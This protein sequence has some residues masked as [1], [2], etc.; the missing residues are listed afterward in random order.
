MDIADCQCCFLEFVFLY[1]RDLVKKLDI[2]IRIL[3]RFSTVTKRSY[4]FFFKTK[5]WPKILAQFGFITV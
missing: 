2:K 5:S 1:L 3:K 4:S